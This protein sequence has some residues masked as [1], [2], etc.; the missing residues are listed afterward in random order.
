MKTRLKEWLVGA[1]MIPIEQER[2]AL[3]Y[4]VYFWRYEEPPVSQSISDNEFSVLLFFP[5]NFLLRI[6]PPSP[7]QPAF[8]GSRMERDVLFT[9]ITIIIIT[10]LITISCS[11]GL[12]PPLSLLHPICI[13]HEK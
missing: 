6:S 2:E 7:Q 9:V 10:T 8:S 5:G 11:T 12:V 1:P 13:Q 4:F 3:L